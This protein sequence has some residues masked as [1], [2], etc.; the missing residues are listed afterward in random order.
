MQRYVIFSMVGLAI[1]MITLMGASSMAVAI[2]G[3]GSDHIF[4]SQSAPTYVY[5]QTSNTTAALPFS[6][7]LSNNTTTTSITDSYVKTVGNNTTTASYSP[8]TLL[9]NVTVND[10][11]LHSANHFVEE[12]QAAGNVTA[13]LGYGHSVGNSTFSFAP[14]EQ[15]SKTGNASVFTNMSF[16]LTP[17]QLSQ[18]S[19]AYMMVQLTFSNAS[20]SFEVSSYVVGN[21]NAGPWYAVGLD[22]GYIILGVGLILTASLSMVWVDVDLGLAKTAVQKATRRTKKGGRK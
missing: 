13:I 21:A 9:T 20:A 18:N 5:G 6:N 22:V 17:A 16:K 4:A 12:V 10:L 19:S 14:L 11:N 7:V 3:H 1:A 2:S 8:I 15:I